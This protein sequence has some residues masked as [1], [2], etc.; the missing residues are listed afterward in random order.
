M[1]YKKIV[2][3]GFVFLLVAGVAAAQPFG[4]FGKFEKLKPKHPHIRPVIIGEGFG[5]SGDEYHVVF[6]SVIKKRNVLPIWVR[7]YLEENNLQELLEKLGNAS[8]DCRGRLV[9]AGERYILRNIEVN[10]THL[11]ADIYGKHQETTNSTEAI[12][13]ITI[14]V[15]RCEGARIGV[16]T[17]TIN[18]ESYRILLNIRRV[19]H[20]F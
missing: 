14:D 4:K 13:H 15:E 19:P 8:L 20:I 3:I 12:G 9:F 1:N 2:C 18:G 5:I 17:I 6:V 11:D 7:E 10:M 16:G